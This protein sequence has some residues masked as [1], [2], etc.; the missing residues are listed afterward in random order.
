MMNK[1]QKNRYAPKAV[2]LFNMLHKRIS[3]FAKKIR[4][5]ILFSLK[6]TLKKLEVII[7]VSTLKNMSLP[8]IQF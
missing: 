8:A 7:N 2:K 4:L 3:L 1:Y 5:S 6:N